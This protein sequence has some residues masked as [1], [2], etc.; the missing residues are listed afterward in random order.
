MKMA[1]AVAAALSCL[2]SLAWAQGQPAPAATQT[3]TPAPK[4]ATKKLAPKAKASSKPAEPA[5]NGPC[6]IGVISAIG[7]Q[8]TV[9]KIGFTVFGNEQAQAPI[10]S[11]GLNDLVVARVRA[12]AGSS[13]GAVR[14]I[15]H[16]R[17]AFTRTEQSGSLFRDAK[18][19]LGNA[20]RQIAT[21]SHCGRYVLVQSSTSQFSNLNQS[22]RGVGIVNWGNPIKDHTYLFALSYIRVYDGQ[23]FEVIKQGAAST[24][25]ESLMSRALML[26]PVRGPSRELDNTSFPST[27]AEAAGNPALRDGVRALLTTSLDKTLPGML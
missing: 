10:D 11:W 14:N 16:A 17:D 18:G 12:A 5:A 2:A 1:L 27:P 21:G 22:V 13:A 20:V 9:Q 7:D 4:V 19:E 25:D 8:F 3:G 6:G 23:S 24:D 15:A 26:Q